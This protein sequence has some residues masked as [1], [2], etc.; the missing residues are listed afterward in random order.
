MRIMELDSD[1]VAARAVASLGLDADAVAIGAP[2]AVCAALRRAGSFLCPAS[3]R[4]LVDV[5]IDA[6]KPVL[7]EATPSREEVNH[8][9]DLLISSGDLLELREGNTRLLYLGPPAWV[10]KSPGWYLLLGVRPNGTPLVDSDLT[11]QI[12]YEGHTRTLELDPDLVQGRLGAAGLREMALDQW[13]RQP[14]AAAA[15][16]VIAD[17][18]TR[19]SAESSAGVVTGLQLLDPATA[20]HYYR[21]RWREVRAIDNG[22]FVC[23]RSQAY[24]AELWCYVRIAEG[25]PLSILDLPIDHL[26][27]GRNEAWRLQA[28]TD[29]LGATPQRYR[30]QHMNDLHAVIDF[31]AP[32]PTW[33]ERRLELVGIP[34]IRSRGALMTYRIASGA[35][36]TVEGFMA[37]MLWMTRREDN[38]RVG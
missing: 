16:D 37:E 29:A 25:R 38:G 18:Q 22:D 8:Y 23:R 15:S 10:T 13:L 28:A 21:G 6:V 19:L 35:L 1:T 17:A 20:V 26:D 14:V 27:L 5:V 31:F 3:P 2:E 30:V 9:L 36:S 11:S 7:S 4:Q 24:G 32:L 33:A 34:V 12:N